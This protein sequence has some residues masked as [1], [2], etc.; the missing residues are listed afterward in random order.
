MARVCCVLNDLRGKCGRVWTEETGTQ[1][2]FAFFISFLCVVLFF[3]IMDM[4]YLYNQKERILSVVCVNEPRV[5]TTGQRVACGRRSPGLR[6]RGV[7]HQEA[8]QDSPHASDRNRGPLGRCSLRGLPRCRLPPQPCPRHP[9]LHRG[10]GCLRPSGPRHRPKDSLRLGSEVARLPPQKPSQ[11][12]RNTGA[13]R[14]L[15]P[16]TPG[17]GLGR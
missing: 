4:N 17:A 15:R 5:V 13:N 1:E 14:A 7:S 11:T 16:R 9:P 8:T 12:D 3:K 2:M 10:S 6:G